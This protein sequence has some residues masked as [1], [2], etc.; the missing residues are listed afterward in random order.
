MHSL[1]GSMAVELRKRRG[2]CRGQGCQAR[3]QRYRR[4]A[5]VRTHVNAGILYRNHYWTKQMAFRSV[6]RSALKDRTMRSVP[7]QCW[8]GKGP[9]ASLSY[10]RPPILERPKMHS[11]MRIKLRM[12]RRSHQHHSPAPCTLRSLA[13]WGGVGGGSCCGAALFVQEAWL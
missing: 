8:P 11:H 5:D 3:N 13:L 6:P 12:A 4:R 10:N 7:Y 9:L 1:Q 2:R